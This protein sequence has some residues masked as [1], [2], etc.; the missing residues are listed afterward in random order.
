[1]IIAIAAL[2]C[3]AVTLAMVALLVP[4][5]DPLQERIHLMG[6]ARAIKAE[7]ESQPSF[8]ERILLP[9]IDSII[10]KVMTVLPPGQMARLRHSLTMA[11]N[12]MS[13]N[14]FLSLV[15]LL[16]LAFLVLPLMG[17]LSMGAPL[18]GPTILWLVMI[19]AL[20]VVLPL[21]WLRGQVRRRQTQIMK[22]LPDALDLIT[23]CVEAGLGLDAALARVS[24]KMKGPLTQEM[25]RALREMS[26]G[27]LRRDALKDMGERTGVP[28]LIAFVHALIQAEQMG[29]SIGRVLRVQANQ[30]RTRRRQRA[31]KAA[32]QAPVKMIFPLVLCIFPSLLVVILG[33]GIISIAKNL[34][35]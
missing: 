22:S 13:I 30:M 32:Y 20:G 35:L 10:Q 25:S 28:D 31:E 23:T 4:I 17:M 11:G 1:M 5:V 21:F 9:I 29:V 7:G 34:K 27:R 24:Q 33:P 3:A 12:P 6:Q 19:M 18:S 16:S 14:V 26:M 8:G 15:A 2:A